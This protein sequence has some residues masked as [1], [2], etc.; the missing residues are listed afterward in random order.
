MSRYLWLLIAIFL[1]SGCATYKFQL[2]KEPAAKGYVVS[3][4]DYIIR[5]YTIGKDNSLPDIQLAKARFKRRRNIVEHYYKNM[6][7]IENH[8]KMA[9]WNPV[10][11]SLKAIGGIFRL[12]FVA[13]SD[14]KYENNPK[15]R[16][17]IK[18]IETEKD[19]REERRIKKLKDELNIYIQ[20][21]LIQ[22]SS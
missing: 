5:E 13:L 22:E 1:I 6:G 10:I 2:S 18:K 14:Y 3:R 7:Y 4:D 19:S 11:I 12:P 21:D 8:L 17:R 9:L 20:R 16:E 15:Y